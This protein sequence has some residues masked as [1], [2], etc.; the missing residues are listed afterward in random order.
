MRLHEIV[1]PKP[2]GRPRA[3]EPTGASEGNRSRRSARIAHVQQQLLE[4]R[5]LRNNT[6]RNLHIRKP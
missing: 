2:D 4:L 6:L 3:I 5:A 1:P